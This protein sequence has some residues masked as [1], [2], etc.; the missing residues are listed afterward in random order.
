MLLTDVSVPGFTRNFKNQI[1]AQW[2]D[3]KGQEL[4]TPSHEYGG[5]I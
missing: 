4:F 3:G 2:Q 5:A 1:I